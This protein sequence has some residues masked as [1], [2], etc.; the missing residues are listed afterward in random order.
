MAYLRS[1]SI[2]DKEKDLIV[3]VMSL[4]M[5]EIVEILKEAM[6]NRKN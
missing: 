1:L 6:E 3:F 2:K 4:E 5:E